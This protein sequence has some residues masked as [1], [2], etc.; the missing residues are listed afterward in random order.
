M[1]KGLWEAQGLWLL[2]DSR[3]ID[4][5]QSRQLLFTH[6]KVEKEEVDHRTKDIWILGKGQ[7]TASFIH[8]TLV[9]EEC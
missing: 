8:C 2:V 6:F 4:I 7:A 3:G 9:W 1:T 5:K